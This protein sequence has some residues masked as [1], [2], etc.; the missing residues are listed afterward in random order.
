[1]A[2]SPSHQEGQTFPLQSSEPS[3]CPCL[4][5]PRQAWFQPCKCTPPTAFPKLSAQVR[6]SP[7][8]ASPPKACFPFDLL[9]SPLYFQEKIQKKSSPGRIPKRK[10][11]EDTFPVGT[12]VNLVLQKT[13]FGV[14]LLGLEPKLPHLLM[15]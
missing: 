15:G 12:A 1:M 7:F 4:V 6:G 8:M 3:W 13:G 11:F 10:E 14:E 2:E 9:N 5:R